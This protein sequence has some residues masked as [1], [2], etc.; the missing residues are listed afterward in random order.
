MTKHALS[1][2]L[3]EDDAASCMK[4]SD[5]ISQL[6][7]VTLVSSTNNASTAIEYMKDYLPDAVIFRVDWRRYIRHRWWW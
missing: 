3:V 5:Y 7:D 4:I 2:L 6:D 1:V